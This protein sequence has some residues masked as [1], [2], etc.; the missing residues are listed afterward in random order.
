MKNPRCPGRRTGPS[1]H[2]PLGPSLI[3]ATESSAA[4]GSARRAAAGRARA[5]VARAGPSSRAGHRAA[6]AASSLRATRAFALCSARN[7]AIRHAA[8]TAA[9]AAAIDANLIV[10][11]GDARRLLDDVL[12]HPLDVP[13][14]DR[15]A[16]RHFA[17]LHAD[18]DLA[19][20][21]LRVPC[22]LLVDVFLDPLI[23]AAVA[24]RSAADVTSAL[25][26]LPALHA[27][28]RA[29]RVAALRSLSGVGATPPEP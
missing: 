23:G 20:I 12:D 29:G 3:G 9:R 21:D 25:P 15:S 5:G 26:G 11:L 16:E 24:F 4:T 7:L 28:E 13:L 1:S 22:Q 6:P 14:V 17:V 10:Y 2:T 27:A 19:G 18:F 8:A